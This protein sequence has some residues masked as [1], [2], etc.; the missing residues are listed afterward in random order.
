MIIELL[1][2]MHP[3]AAREVVDD[4]LLYEEIPA[5]FQQH[6]DGEGTTPIASAAVVRQSPPVA[7][8]QWPEMQAQALSTIAAKCV[9]SQAK[10]RATIAEALPELERLLRD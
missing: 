2:S 1:T 9:R 4:S 5:L 10:L 8:C 7:K 3:V 6:H